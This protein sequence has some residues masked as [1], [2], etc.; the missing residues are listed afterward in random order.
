MKCATKIGT[1]QH[2][3]KRA[4]S[5]THT[6]TKQE[7]V[8]TQQCPTHTQWIYYTKNTPHALC[9]VCVCV[10]GGCVCRLG[11]SE[12][13]LPDVD[14]LCT[15][16]GTWPLTE[17]QV[18]CDLQKQD[19]QKQ[20]MQYIYIYIQN[21]QNKNQANKKQKQNKKARAV[22]TFKVPFACGVRQRSFLILD[23]P[24]RKR[25]RINMERNT[26]MYMRTGFK[27]VKLTS[28]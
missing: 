2:R 25:R 20:D 6:H 22:T 16:P 3:P 11:W 9:V 8:H 26:C 18:A 14:P 21:K 23:N 5:I 17:T 4:S 15:W 1:M 19:M 28:K 13:R 7:S 12:P 27:Q 24:A 10:W